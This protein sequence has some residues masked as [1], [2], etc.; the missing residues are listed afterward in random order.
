MNKDIKIKELFKDIYG[1]YF[2]ELNQEYLID[3]SEK[4][5]SNKCASCGDKCISYS[6]R[7]DLPYF[8]LTDNIKTLVI[9]ES[10]A[11]G[12]DINKLGYV[13][14][15]E[16]F[17]KP[18]K[19][20]IKHYENYFFKLLNLNREETYITDAVKCYSH[21][22]NFSKAFK[23]CNQ[24]LLKEIEILEPKKILVISK[25]SS[26]IKF[27]NENK[28]KYN[29][30]ITIIPHPSNQNI[31]KIPTVSELFIKIGELNHNEKWIRIGNEINEEYKKFRN[32]LNQ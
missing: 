8:K 18:S 30:E 25:Q 13:F 15:W 12:E 3:N 23:N 24:Y 1:V 11:S 4:S 32:K 20:I 2:Q 17:G 6:K 16:Q 22:S 31:G 7:Q 10:P 28:E 19:A 21:K 27:L 5:H 26:V 29:Y 9:A 14:G